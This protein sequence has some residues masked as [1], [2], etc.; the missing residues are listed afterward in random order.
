M[1]LLNYTTT[2]DAAKTVAEIQRLLV[3]FGATRF[4]ISYDKGR[5]PES[6]EFA[7]PTEVGEQHFRLPANIPGVE[8]A[9]KRQHLAGK[10]QRRYTDPDH[11]ARV[12]WRI[13]KDRLVVELAYVEAGIAPLDQV[14]CAHLVG[15]DGRT[16][17][18]LVRDQ[19]LSL[20]P[21]GKD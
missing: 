6:V 21:P 3:A 8:S 14:L 15:R 2:V 5:R 17:H 20:P 9:L 12:A 1:P 19:I 7:S 16:V 11:A 18:Q 10:L 13:V 4:S